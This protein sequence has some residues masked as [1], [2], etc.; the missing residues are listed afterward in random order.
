[1]HKLLERQ[2]LL[3]ESKEDLKKSDFWAKK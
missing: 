2:F 3:L 1:L